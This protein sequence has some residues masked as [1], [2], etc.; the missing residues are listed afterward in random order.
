MNSV[1]D[2][3]FREC[4]KCLG[5][6]ISTNE[7]K[8]KPFS[9]TFEPLGV[10]IDFS[11]RQSVVVSNKPSRVESMIQLIDVLVSSKTLSSKQAAS[12]KGKL[13]FMEGQHW[14]RT[15]NM[16]MRTLSFIAEHGSNFNSIDTQLIEELRLAKKCLTSS[17]PRSVPSLWP[18]GEILL[19]TDGAHEP[20]ENK[21]LVT[22]GA[23]LIADCF[24]IRQFFRLVIP[25]LIVNHWKSTGRKQCVGQAELFPVLVSKLVWREFLNNRLSLVFVDNES[26]K[27][28]LINRYSPVLDSS[29]LLW[30]ISVVDSSLQSRDWFARVSS[31]SNIADEPSRLKRPLAELGHFHEVQV[32]PLDS[33]ILSIVLGK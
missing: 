15:L 7:K 18:D 24:G 13:T 33:E 16:S 1:F 29:R 32:D 14:N 9:R 25:D 26:A 21:D 4:L 3:A 19:F 8:D 22:C 31:F 30:A 20:G 28:A 27:A 23:V 12:L 11:N 5:W 10:S 6:R 2:F 17:K